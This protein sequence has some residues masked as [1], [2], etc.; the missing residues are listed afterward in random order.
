MN[1]NIGSNNTFSS[2]ETIVYY[3]FTGRLEAKLVTI[4]SHTWNALRKAV[5]RALVMAGLGVH[6]VL[7]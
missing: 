5:S 6:L 3:F 7:S 1:T 2:I 4:G